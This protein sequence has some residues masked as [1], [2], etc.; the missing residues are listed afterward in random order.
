ML[1]LTKI[2]FGPTRPLKFLHQTS[3]SIISVCQTVSVKVGSRI[4]LQLS[5]LNIFS[6]K[7]GPKNDQYS[8]PGK[9]KKCFVFQ[10]AVILNYSIYLCN[11]S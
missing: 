5:K 9:L 1:Q 4:M 2:P 10:A 7:L 11:G 8:I 3:K 6:A